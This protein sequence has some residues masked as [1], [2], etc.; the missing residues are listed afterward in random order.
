M[1]TR[2]VDKANDLATRIRA[3]K[4]ARAAGISVRPERGVYRNPPRL[5]IEERCACTNCERPFPA[6]KLS[7]PYEN[8]YGIGPTD[9]RWCNDCITSAGEAQDKARDEDFYGA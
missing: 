2:V 3:E 4:A 8:P 6:D 7:S 5:T 9:E 1:N